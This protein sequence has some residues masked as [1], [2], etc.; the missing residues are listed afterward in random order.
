MAAIMNASHS[1]PKIK[2][3]HKQA[4]PSCVKQRRRPQFVTSCSLPDIHTTVQA[5]PSIVK[6]CLELAALVVG[7]AMGGTVGIVFEEEIFRKGRGGFMSGIYGLLI[8]SPI[9]AALFSV[10]VALYVF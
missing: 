1:L 6:V 8:G 4:R 5:A 2:W 9:G 7:A 3:C 10:L